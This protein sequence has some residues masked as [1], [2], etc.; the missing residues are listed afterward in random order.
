MVIR[1]GII[2]GVQGRDGPPAAAFPLVLLGNGLHLIVNLHDI[3]PEEHVIV[4]QVRVSYHL[5]L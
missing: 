4:R 1:I 3:G 2:V 5:Y